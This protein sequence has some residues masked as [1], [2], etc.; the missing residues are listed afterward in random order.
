MD[1][2]NKL[3]LLNWCLVILTPT[4]AATYIDCA[5]VSLSGV[6]VSGLPVLADKNGAILGSE[7]ET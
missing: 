1:P 6:A 7:E 2:P 4:P 3:M 5:S